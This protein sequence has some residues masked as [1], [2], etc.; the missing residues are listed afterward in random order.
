MQVDEVSLDRLRAGE[1]NASWYPLMEYPG[2]S[3]D[4][5]RAIS[6]SGTVSFVRSAAEGAWNV[7]AKWNDLLPH[8]KFVTADE[9]LTKIW[10]KRE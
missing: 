10:G 6:K 8:Y 5:I 4:Q 9:Y 3:E 1:L 2:F 7:S